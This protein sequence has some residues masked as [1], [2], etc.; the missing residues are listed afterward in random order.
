MEF[1]FPVEVEDHKSFCGTLLSNPGKDFYLAIVSSIAELDISFSELSDD[2]EKTRISK[3][4]SFGRPKPLEYPAELDHLARVSFVPNAVFYQ[5]R[6]QYNATK[7]R[8]RCHPRKS[9]G[10][11]EVPRTKWFYDLCRVLYHQAI[12]RP[13]VSKR[14]PA[15]VQWNTRTLQQKFDVGSMSFC[16]I[17]TK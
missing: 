1:S 9:G 17:M 4:Y 13:V 15:V 11:Y 3:F 5:H 6:L 8:Y 12:K 7:L 16:F 10:L 14:L 2:P